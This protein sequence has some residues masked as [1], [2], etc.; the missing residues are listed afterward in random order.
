MKLNAIYNNIC[1]RFKSVSENPRFEAKELIKY[2]CN[3]SETEFLLGR[4]DEITCEIEEKIFNFSKRRLSGVPLQYIIGEWDFM[5]R[6]FKVG[7]GVLIPRPETE[8]LCQYVID[9]VS[10]KATPCVI[11]LCSGSGCIAIS[12]KLE[13]ENTD[14]Y[15]VEKSAEAFMYLKNNTENLCIDEPITFING[16]IFDIDAFKDIPKADVIVSNPPYINTADIASL[17]RE[18]KFEP[19]MALDGG[20]DGLDFYRFIVAEWKSFLKDDGIFAFECGEDQADKIGEIL[21]DNGFDSFILKD[22]NDIDRFVV[23][24]R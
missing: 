5:G 7:E 14:V 17:Q 18:V 2:V 9:C 10:D 4:N 15:A 19:V 23:G 21:K 6:T 24:R 11:D 1:E 13:A 12:I 8:L 3:L 22:Y 16:D 20:V